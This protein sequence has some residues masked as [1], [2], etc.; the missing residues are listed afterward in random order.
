MSAGTRLF[1]IGVVSCIVLLIAGVTLF[2]WTQYQAV[3]PPST[4]SVFDVAPPAAPP[5][6][7]REVPPGPEK[8]HKERQTPVPDVARIEPPLVHVPGIKPP[9]VVVAEPVPDPGPPVKETTAPEIKPAPPAPQVSI[10][11]PTWEGLVLGALNRV[12]R[13]PRDA[14]FRRQQGMPY[15]RFVMDRDGRIVS[16]RLESSSGIRSLDNEAVSL[17]K[18]AQPLPKPPAELTGDRIELVVPVEFF[19]R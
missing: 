8:D 16:S 2:T 1:G 6:P 11:K 12:K 10:S 13:Y 18:R 14:S 17:P 19:M 3:T 4:L 7:V 9:Q 5:E 15:I